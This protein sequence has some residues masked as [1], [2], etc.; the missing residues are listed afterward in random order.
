[1]R[2]RP[3]STQASVTLVALCF[4]VVLAIALSSYLMLCQRS[5]D[6][7]TRQRHNDDVR[8]LAQVGLEEALWALNQ[9]NW[10]S[11]GP[12]GSSSWA[13]SG[14]D[15]TLT[16][17]YPALSPGVTG[18]VV[19]TVANYASTG[20]AWPTI[21][22]AATLTL[23]D[24]QTMAKILR[25]T[26]Q[27]APLFGN[28]IASATSYVSFA[29]GGT[30]DSWNSDPGNTGHYT[31]PYAF[32]A[33]NASNY[34]AVVAGDTNGTNGVVLNQALVNGYVATLGKPISY[35]TSGTPGGRIK[36][37]VTPA[38]VNVDPLRIGK[39][40]FIPTYP[41]FQVT[42]PPTSGPAFGGLLGDI[43]GLVA[44]L[45]GAPPSQD[46]FEVTGNLSIQGIPL[47][48]PSLTI[49][50]PTKII[51]DG[52]FTTSNVG[53]ITVTNTGSLEMFIAGDVT[54][55]G[56]GIDNQ[57]SDPSKV[58]LFCTSGSTTNSLRYTSTANFCGVIYCV[59]KP[60]DIQ[61]NATFSGALLSGQYVRFSGSATAPVFHYDTALRARRFNFVTT[62][63]VIRQLTEP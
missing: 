42:T 44:A 60:I 26:T 51:V 31:T 30:V 7:S 12:G 54:L 15:R 33:G 47:L 11:S 41:V 14:A 53:K 6:L 8:E 10:T 25:A 50:R 5:Y 56:L 22:S 23:D 19:L 28:A 2:G 55:G 36:G 43:L 35:S 29:S 57:T 13:T 21:T 37:P 3:D 27:P 38:G 32:T 9:G 59:N 62:P 46:T 16:L 24:G 52:N 4:T 48:S 34:A 49:D 18:T 17:S 58:A 39:S 40:A 61:Q 20:P 45:L 63:F 1:M